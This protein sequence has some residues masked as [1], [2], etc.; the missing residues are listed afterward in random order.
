[1]ADL[2]YWPFDPGIVL[3]YPGASQ[4]AIRPQ[5]YGTDF[6]VAAG[7]P[8]RATIS[9][10]VRLTWNDGYGAY[11]LDIVAPSGTVIRNGHLSR[12]DVAHGAWVDAGDWIGLTGG[13]PGTPGAGLSTG[14]HLHWEIRDNIRWDGYGWYDPRDLEIHHF[15]ELDAPPATTSSAA[16]PPLLGMESEMIV[17]YAHALGKGRPGWLVMGYSPRALVLSTQS[18]A[19]EWARRIGKETISTGYEG[20]RKYLRAAGGTVAQLATVSKG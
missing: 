17:Y 14:V 15:A 8:L 11:V 18:A 10:T 20:F 2:I 3:E 6:P 9:G 4:L 12:M 16:L 19:N 7:T 13:R 5:H 1:M